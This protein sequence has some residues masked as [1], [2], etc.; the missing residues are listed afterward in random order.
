MVSNRATKTLLEL[1]DFLDKFFFLIIFCW[2]LKSQKRKQQNVNVSVT[3]GG[4]IS[5]GSIPFSI[6]KILEILKELRT[7]FC[8]IYTSLGL[9]L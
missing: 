4:T 7:L 6:I 8:K 5:P 1:I 9:K 3:M 2:S